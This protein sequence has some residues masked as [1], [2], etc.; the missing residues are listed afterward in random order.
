MQLRRAWLQ[1]ADVRCGEG[2]GVSV[3][4]ESIL[5]KVQAP[6]QVRSLTG[7]VIRLDDEQRAVLRLMCQGMQQKQ[8]TAELF[9]GLDKV[10]RASASLMELS[11]CR[12]HAQLGAWAQREHLL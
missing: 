4:F 9:I 1:R 5:A 6:R 2:W 7:R 3:T 8:I 12:S 11:E 10:R